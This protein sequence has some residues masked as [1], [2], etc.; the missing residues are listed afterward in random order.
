MKP[1][2]H[3]L[4]QVPCTF[5]IRNGPF[6]LKFRLYI[7]IYRLL[8]FIKPIGLASCFASTSDV[9]THAV[10]RKLAYC[11]TW[12]EIQDGFIFVT[13]AAL[14]HASLALFVLSLLAFLELSLLAFLP[15]FS[16]F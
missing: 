12:W 1:Q 11:S 14:F 3:F 7:Y 10:A 2:V 6:G 13:I 5:P 16:V 15:V 8:L 4:L 9:L